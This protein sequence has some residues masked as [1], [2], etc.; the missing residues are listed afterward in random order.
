MICLLV[1]IMIIAGIIAILITHYN[2]CRPKAKFIISVYSE[3]FIF[4]GDNVMVSMSYSQKVIV[5]IAPVDSNGNPASVEA[6]SVQVTSSDES[7]ALLRRDTENELKFEILGNNEGRTGVA[8][9]D[10]K[11]D[12]DLGEGVVT[13][14]GFI[15]VE[16]LPKQAVG[17]GFVIGEPVE[18]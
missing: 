13:I 8:Q 11:A 16:V 2:S 1:V 17:F 3:N 15:G 10:L 6:G 12:A 14:E 18:Q 7:I 5:E 9:I 4:K